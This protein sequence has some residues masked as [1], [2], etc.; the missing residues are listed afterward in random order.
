MVKATKVGTKKKASDLLAEAGEETVLVV[1]S[2]SDLDTQEDLEE[3]IALFSSNA[4]VSQGSVAYLVY[5]IPGTDQYVF[6]DLNKLPA[7]YRVTLITGNTSGE[8]HSKSMWEGTSGNQPQPID[9]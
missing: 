1:R 4:G 9:S 3:Q 6:F 5:G 7:T 2:T 8:V